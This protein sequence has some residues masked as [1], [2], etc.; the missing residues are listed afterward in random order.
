[1]IKYL[2][3]LRRKKGFTLVELIVVIAILAV[4]TTVV[5]VNMDNVGKKIK[6]AN[7]AASDFYVAIQSAFTRYMT[8][9]GALSP[10]LAAEANPVMKYYPAAGG[11][12]PRPM[13]SAIVCTDDKYPSPCDLYLELEAYNG[14]IQ[15]VNVARNF[16]DVLSLPESTSSEFA[17]LLQMEIEKRIDFRNGFYYAHIKCK[18]EYNIINPVKPT[19]MDTVYVEY[20]AFAFERIDKS[21]A[22]NYVFSDRD[23]V[24]LNGEPCGVC[25][26]IPESALTKKM[27]FAGTNLAS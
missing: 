18:P 27:G 2:Q 11:N 26:P 25:A 14:K 7:S 23:Y 20:A 15:Y 8:Y 21:S 16:I 13:S 12:Y 9:P 17:R 22:N 4:M 6:S 10:T 3:R 1:M 19:L 24:L 5:L